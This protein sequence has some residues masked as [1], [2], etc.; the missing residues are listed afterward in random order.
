MGLGR[1]ELD[2]ALNAF[3][4]IE[5]L[6]VDFE[7]ARLDLGEIQNLVDQAQQR[8]GGAIDRPP[9]RRAAPPKDRVSSINADMPRIPFIGVRISW[10]MAAR[11]RD[12]AWLAACA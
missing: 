1:H 6:R 8:P 11:N 3:V 10:L 12:L 7:L 5:G 2:D 9:H 4:E